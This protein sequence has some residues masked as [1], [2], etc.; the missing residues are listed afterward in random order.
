MKKKL[1][2][3]IF[4]FLATAGLAT[5]AYAQIAPSFQNNFG[6]YLVDD[7]P[8]EFGRVETVFNFNGCISRDFSLRQNIQNLFYPN[9]INPS[10]VCTSSR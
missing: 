6:D 8:D 5:V 2:L 3:I 7:T 10:I 1:S 4:L 9:I